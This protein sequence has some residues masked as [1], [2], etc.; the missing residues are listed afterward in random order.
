MVHCGL[1]NLGIGCPLVT[2]LVCLTSNK[3]AALGKSAL[4]TL[5]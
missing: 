3:S 4:N 1:N 5:D 2:L